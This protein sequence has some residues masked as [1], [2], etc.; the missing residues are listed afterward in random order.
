MH[1]YLYILSGKSSV[2]FFF[3]FW[4]RLIVLIAF[5]IFCIKLFYLTGIVLFFAIGLGTSNYTFI[6]SQLFCIVL[7]FLKSLDVFYYYY[8]YATSVYVKSCKNIL[9]FNLILLPNFRELICIIKKSRLH[10][11]LRSLLRFV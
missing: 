3:C 1:M 7:F 10:R 5:P 8:Y 9:F 6:F 2:T 11:V 4:S